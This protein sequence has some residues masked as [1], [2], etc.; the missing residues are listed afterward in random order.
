MLVDN[1]VAELTHGQPDGAPQRSGP[2]APSIAPYALLRFATLPV[3]MLAAMRPSRTLDA[4][5]SSLAAEA[6]M[7]RDVDR[8]AD[9]LFALVG[10]T[11]P[12]DKRLRR[13]MPQVTDPN[14][15]TRY[16]AAMLAWVAGS[17][18]LFAA[19]WT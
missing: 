12:E 17:A 1:E 5:D 11:A 15:V 2:A 7:G 4:V 8:L 19:W 16:R 18:L 10:R 6:A 14:V 9:A 13:A 3:D